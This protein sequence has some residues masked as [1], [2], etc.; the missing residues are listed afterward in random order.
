MLRNDHGGGSG[1]PLSPSHLQMFWSPPEGHKR[2]GY[3]LYVQ[4]RE[5]ALSPSRHFPEHLYGLPPQDGW[6]I[7]TDE[8]MARTIS[9]VLDKSQTDELGNIPTGGRIRS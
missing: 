8:S 1:T 9:E 7:R 6:T 5:R 2:Q 4:I 3:M